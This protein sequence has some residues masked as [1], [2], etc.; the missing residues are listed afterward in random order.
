M[1]CCLYHKWSISSQGS[2]NRSSQRNIFEDYDKEEK[3]RTSILSASI[4][5][6]DM[7]E[8]MLEDLQE[9]VINDRYCTNNIPTIFKLLSGNQLM[10]TGSSV[11]YKSEIFFTHGRPH[12]KPRLDPL[13]SRAH[14]D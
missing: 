12:S 9:V 14:Q 2:F 4:E 6:L 8:P 11:G 10:E 5:N 1:C 3:N 7:I 13:K